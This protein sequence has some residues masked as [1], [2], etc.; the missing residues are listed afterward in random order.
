V[1][2]TPIK[3]TQRISTVLREPFGKRGVVNN[4]FTLGRLGYQCIFFSFSCYKNSGRTITIRRVD[5]MIETIVNN[6]ADMNTWEASIA[7]IKGFA[8]ILA[9]KIAL[10]MRKNKTQKEMK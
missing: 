3:S 7:V 4:R 6:V 10:S 9:V 1:E 8:G 5:R 2:E